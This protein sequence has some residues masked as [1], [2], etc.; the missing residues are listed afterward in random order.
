[1]TFYT[2]TC[3][4]FPGM[5]ECPGKVQA[6][7]EQELWQLIET[8]ARVAHGENVAEWSEEDKTQVAALIKTVE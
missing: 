6:E 3:S 1:M 2:Y 5:E 7:T 8:H 4:E